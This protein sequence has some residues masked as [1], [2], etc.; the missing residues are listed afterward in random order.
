MDENRL[1]DIEI[2]LAHQEQLL[3]QLN[4][5]LADQQAQ[6]MQ[7]IELCQSVIERMKSLPHDGADSESADERPP[8]Y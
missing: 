1:I 6:L 8:H 2:K 5:A 4:D 3:A 7:V